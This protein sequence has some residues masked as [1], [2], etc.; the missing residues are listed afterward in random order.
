M[1]ASKS[2]FKKYK[3]YIKKQLS[4]MMPVLV[5]IAM[6]D[7]SAKIKVPEKENEFTGLLVALNLM[8]EELK[9]IKEAERRSEK[10]RKSAERS[11]VEA[12][13][14]VKKNLEREV[15][16]RTRELQNKVEELEK[17]N[18][19]AIGRELKMV[20]L[21]KEAERLKKDLVKNKQLN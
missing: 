9:A 10:A 12:L 3:K 17:F 18:K 14:E 7:F 20:A 8:I 19:I 15:Q 2:E 4:G 16:K 21:K 1:P 5:R 13:I 11:K 6:G